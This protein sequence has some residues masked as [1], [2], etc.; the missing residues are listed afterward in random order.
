MGRASIIG[1]EPL[2]REDAGEIIRHLKQRGVHTAMNTNGWLVPDRIDDVAH[3]DLVCLTLDGPK[4]VHDEQRRKGSYDRVLR[5]LE[6][7]K[8]RSVPAVTMTVLTPSGADN[9]EHV[10]EVAREHGHKAFFQLEHDKNCDVMA[11]IAPRLSDRRIEDLASHLIELKRAGAP[12]GNSYMVLERQRD[13]GRYLGSCEE[14]YAG[15]Y[16]GYVLSDGTVA[17]CL[18]TQWQQTRGNGRSLGFTRAF[19]EMAA[20]EGPGCSC[21]PTHEVNQVLSFDPRAIWHAVE[22]TLDASAAG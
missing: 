17:P 12:V 14:C 10:L 22:V 6:A 18:L 13:R 2:L 20:P 1:G 4:A 11:P 7:L 15:T 3:L 8:S 16:Y 19:Q 9:V 5:A 21:V